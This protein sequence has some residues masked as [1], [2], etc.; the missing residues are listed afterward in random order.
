MEAD[1]WVTES[2]LDLS[3]IVFGTRK[4]ARAKPFSPSVGLASFKGGQEARAPSQTQATT[5]V[6]MPNKQRAQQRRPLVR[7]R[8]LLPSSNSFGQCCRCATLVLGDAACG[9]VAGGSVTGSSTG[10]RDT[11]ELAWQAIRW[12]GRRVRVRLKA[13]PTRAPMHSEGCTKSGG[14]KCRGA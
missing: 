5:T 2:G 12:I 14:P 8:S 4:R 7:G 1:G 3:Q 13:M 11:G 10:R 9:R 6:P